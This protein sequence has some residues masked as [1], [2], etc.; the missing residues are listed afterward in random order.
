MRQIKVNVNIPGFRVKSFYIITTL[1]DSERYSVESLADLYCQR[2]DV[3]L[4]FRDIKTT[5]GMDILRC[6]TPEMTEKEILMYFIVY[7]SIRMLMLDAGN[8]VNLFTLEISF[9][10]SVQ[11]LRQWEP[12]IKRIDINQK[13]RNRLIRLLKSTIASAGILS[14]PERHEPRAVKRRPNPVALLTA[15]RHEMKVTRYGGKYSAKLA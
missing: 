4:F 13:E 6:K 1:L 3:E 8:E 11:A 5:K 14:R 10:A 15:P 12:Q 2:W 9:K 7:N